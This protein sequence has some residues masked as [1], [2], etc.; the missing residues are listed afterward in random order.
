MPTTIRTTEP[1][2]LLSLVPYQ[3]GFRPEDSAVLVSLRGER[4]RVGLVARVD[5]EDL[6]D[7]STGPTLARTLV[8]HLEHDGARHAVLVLYPAPGSDL[9]RT[10]AAR[11]AVEIAAGEWL[12][13]LACWVVGETGW[14]SP[15]CVD[16]GCCPPGGR[17]LAELEST[18]VGAHMVLS[19]TAVLSHRGELGALP[20]AEP[21]AR[22]SARRAAARW[23]ERGRRALPV[24]TEAGRWRA[25]SF[26]L[27]RTLVT[28]STVAPSSR[29]G[30]GT[31]PEIGRLIAAL[32]DL[33]CRDAVLL[34]LLPGGVA[35]AERLLAGDDSDVGGALGTLMD[36]VDG[37][38]PQE[39]AIAPAV[40]VLETVA[41]HASRRAAAPALT[42]LAVVAWWQGDGARAGLHVE[43]ALDGDPDHRLA[44]LLAETLAAGLP[45]G[46]VRARRG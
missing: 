11:E 37:V 32:D 24:P 31:P 23:S 46:W 9:A 42:L 10:A 33:L 22:R 34:S 18:Q 8:R 20:E 12:G 26:A 36:P 3:L 43:R 28:R 44:R 16:P 7:P 6:A 39:E 17:P 29:R 13:P 45:P 5:L 38:A 41:A 2:E 4:G 14:W 19:G 25:E 15:D 21:R 40:R 30:P 1:R 35:V 27:W